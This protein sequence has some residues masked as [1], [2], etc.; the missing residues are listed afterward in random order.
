M[1]KII[2][3]G[4]LKE[5]EDTSQF[6]EKAFEDKKY[7]ECM[8]IYLKCKDTE[9]KF[10]SIVQELND[11]IDDIENTRRIAEIFVNEELGK[12]G[13]TLDYEYMR[14]RMCAFEDVLAK[15]RKISN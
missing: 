1:I 13:K 6:L 12:N 2:L 9:K 15:A 10:N 4:N 5:L 3:E 7:T 11:L 8:I 14:G